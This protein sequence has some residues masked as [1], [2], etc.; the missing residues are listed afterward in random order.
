MPASLMKVPFLITYLKMSEKNPS[1]LNEKYTFN[2]TYNS[3]KTQEILSKSIEPG[4]SYTVKELIQSMIQYSDNNAT[5]LLAEHID[6]DVLNAVF[7][8]FGLQKPQMGSSNLFMSADEYSRFMRALINGTYLT[9]ANSEMAIDILTQSVFDQGIQHDL[10][11]SIAI[12]HK[13]GE[14]GNEKEQQ[15]HESGIVYLENKPYLITVM[16]KG[17]NK[18]KLEEVIQKISYKVFNS[19]KS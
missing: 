17:S 7:T 3:A 6:N 11:K 9:K 16:T 5:F 19:M 8:D 18:L 13:F 10:P 1:L 12:A 14:S 2:N 15:L 4:K